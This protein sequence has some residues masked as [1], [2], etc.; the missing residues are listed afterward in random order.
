MSVPKTETIVKYGLDC[1]GDLAEKAQKIRDDKHDEAGWE[2]V[3]GKEESLRRESEA[4][5][6]VARALWEATQARRRASDEAYAR[7]YDRTPA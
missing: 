3:D 7:I 6:D 5:G 4:W 1:L 2:Y